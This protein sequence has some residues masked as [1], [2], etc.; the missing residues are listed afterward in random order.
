MLGPG[1]IS[2]DHAADIEVTGWAGGGIA[3]GVAVVA[4]AGLLAASWAPRAPRRAGRDDGGR[5]RYG[6]GRAGNR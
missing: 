1:K 3:L 5:V 6:S 2:V 4:T